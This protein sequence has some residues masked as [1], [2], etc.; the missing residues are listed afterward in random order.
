MFKKI[1]CAFLVFGMG[2]AHALMP[3]TGTWV[4]TSEL[5][6]K[7]G[8]GIALDVQNDT[9][10]MQIYAY[11]QSGQPTFYMGVGQINANGFASVPLGRYSGGR[12]FGSGPQ[13]GSDAGSPG[14]VALRFTSGTTGFASFPGEPEQAISRFNFAYPFAPASLRGLWTITSLNTTS[15]FTEAGILSVMGPATANGNGLISSTDGTFFCEHQ[16]RGSSAGLLFC[17]RI[18]VQGQLLR[19]YALTYT[20]N[21]GEGYQFTPSGGQTDYTVFVR[22]ITTPNG[23]GT[24][25]IFKNEEIAN[26]DFGVQQQYIQ[27][28]AENFQ[29]H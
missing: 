10:V 24:G 12:Y 20:V 16:V 13:S 6:G 26:I 11:E 14:T 21:E 3:Q 23:I 7:P 22:R 29:R 4:V 28:I 5:N 9:L 2:L 18:N 17:A 15:V 8:R 19:S 25:L 1:V 27:R